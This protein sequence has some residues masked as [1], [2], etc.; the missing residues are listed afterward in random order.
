GI[1]WMINLYNFMDGIDGIAATETVMVCALAGILLLA[2]GASIIA[3]T[4]WAL[5]AACLGFLRWNWAPAQIFMG[6]V[7]SGF[8]GYCIAMLAIVSSREGSFPLWVWLILLG[9][10]VVDA[11]VTLLRRMK[12]RLKWYEAHHSHAYQHATE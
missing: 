3:W 1:V 9:A 11:G 6:D 10:F 2:S 4:A 7:G 12:Q 5:A 8:L